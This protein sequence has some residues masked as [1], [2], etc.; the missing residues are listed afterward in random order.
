MS[1][2]NY[3]LK[4]RP[5]G[6]FSCSLAAAAVVGVAAATAAVPTTAEHDQ[7]QNNDPPPVV[8]AKTADTVGIAIHNYDLL[9]EIGGLP[10]SFHD[11]SQVFFGYSKRAVMGANVYPMSFHFVKSSSKIAALVL[12]V[13]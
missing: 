10:R 3:Q 2:V 11:M 13:E 6:R 4:K 1:I 7:D 9:K 8:A 12:D 5:Y